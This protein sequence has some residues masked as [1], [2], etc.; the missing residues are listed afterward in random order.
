MII[1]KKKFNGLLS[2]IAD[3]QVENAILEGQNNYLNYQLEIQ[4]MENKGL[5][6]L[7]EEKKK[8]EKQTKPKKKVGRPKKEK[9]NK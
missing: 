2:Q 1:T 6:E 7:I 8:N 3:L 5:K 9:T 4:K